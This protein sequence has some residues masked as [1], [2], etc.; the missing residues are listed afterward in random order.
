M[1]DPKRQAQN[2][3]FCGSAQLVPYTESKP[4]FRPESVLPFTVSETGARDGI[5]AWYGKL[6]LAPSALKRR[7]LTD[8]VRGMYLPYWTFDAHVDAAWT[9]E[10]GHYYYTTET[11]SEGGQT[12]T[13]QVQH[14]RWE[15]AAG[16]LQHDFDDDLV[17]ASV[18]VHPELLRGIEPFPTQALK[19]YDAGFVA[20][21]IV[22]RYQIDLVAAAQRAA[23]RDG[24][25]GP[26]DVRAAG[27]G[28]HVPQPRRARRLFGADVQ[29]HPRARVVPVLPLRLTRVPVRDERRDRHDPR[30]ISEEPVEGRAAGARDSRRR[31]HR[32]VAG[33]P[34]LTPALPRP[35]AHP[36][37][38]PLSRWLRPDCFARPPS[39]AELD[40]TACAAGLRRA[41][42]APLR[43]VAASA[44][45]ESALDYERRI[46]TRGEIAVRAGSLHDFCNALAWLA[47]PRTKAALNAVHVASRPASAAGTRSRPRDAATLLDE[48]GMLVACADT[49]LLRQWDARDWRTGF[50]DLHATPTAP[51]RAVAIG[52]GLL[53][54]C[55]RPYPT[56][57]AHALVLPV[58]ASRLPAAP[59]AFAAALDA[60]AAQWI[61]DAGAAWSPASLRPLPLAA[62]PGWAGAASGTL[63]F[64]DASVFRP[65]RP[66]SLTQPAPPGGPVVLG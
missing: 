47:F 7:A 17:C 1:L 22:E 5:R 20:G 51:L 39:V 57:T 49:T 29:A 21:W 27:S 56:L 63:R 28:R 35:E 31:R 24:R 59:E 23:R 11:Y 6:W 55:V 18:G 62:L 61:A 34:A 37:F 2:C 40:A 25:E 48:S 26:R 65:R 38:A 19:P 66:R 52:H 10:A 50:G 13:R 53:A 9:A 4:A 41:G 45:R 60:A 36:A 54:K 46:A 3:E 30:R 14:V 15:P 33:R 42:G 58:T 43:F 12:R 64:D 32:A 16:R 44:R 8:T